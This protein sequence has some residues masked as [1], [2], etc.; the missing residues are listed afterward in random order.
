MVRSPISAPD[1]RVGHTTAYEIVVANSPQ[2][3]QGR[4]R[5]WGAYV[6]I[7]DQAS[8]VNAYVAVTQAHLKSG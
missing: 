7:N 2:C 1:V 6:F 5:H 8:D 4:R 3:G